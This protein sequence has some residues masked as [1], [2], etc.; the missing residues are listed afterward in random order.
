MRNSTSTGT[1]LPTA[2]ISDSRP[3]TANHGRPLPGMVPVLCHVSYPSLIPLH[4]SRPLP[5]SSRHARSHAANR[6]AHPHRAMQTVLNRLLSD[7]DGHHALSPSPSTVQPEPTQLA[8]VP[9]G[10]QGRGVPQCSS[11]ALLGGSRLQGCRGAWCG[12]LSW[13]HGD[14]TAVLTNLVQAKDSSS[15]HGFLTGE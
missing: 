9:A 10:G 6:P 8:A 4:R 14:Y 1:A 13:G 5:S 7:L 15:Q 2:V 3:L 12:V 11:S